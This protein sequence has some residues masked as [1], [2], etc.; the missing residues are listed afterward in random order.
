MERA[1]LLSCRFQKGELRGRHLSL[2]MGT[3]CCAPLPRPAIR[4]PQPAAAE[5]KVKEKG[6][7]KI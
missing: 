6:E 5:V 1:V 3:V 2:D 4:P 7:R